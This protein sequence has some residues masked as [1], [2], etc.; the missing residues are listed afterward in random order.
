MRETG[1]GMVMEARA[2]ASKKSLS[3]SEVARNSSSFFLCDCDFRDIWNWIRIFL[4]HY[5]SVVCFKGKGQES[6]RKNCGSKAEP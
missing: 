6:K 5:Y 3:G 1:G 2:F 4:W